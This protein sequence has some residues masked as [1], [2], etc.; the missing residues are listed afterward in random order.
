MTNRADTLCVLCVNVYCVCVPVHN[1]CG[2]CCAFCDQLYT[3]FRTIIYRW[4]YFV[5]RDAERLEQDINLHIKVSAKQIKRTTKCQALQVHV[6]VEILVNWFLA[7]NILRYLTCLLAAKYLFKTPLQTR[8]TF[9]RISLA[10]LQKF[11]QA[12]NELQSNYYVDVNR[13]EGK[14]CWSLETKRLALN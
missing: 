3:T 13:T 10:E 9:W 7:P 12:Q 5:W 2:Y 11:L 6:V 8:D 14:K 4:K 1:V